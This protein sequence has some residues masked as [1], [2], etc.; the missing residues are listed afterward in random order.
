MC[1]VWNITTLLCAHNRDTETGQEE[2]EEEKHIRFKLN[3]QKYFVIETEI[4]M[5]DR[6]VLKT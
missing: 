3:E 4:E 1:R 5:A 6:R 2:E